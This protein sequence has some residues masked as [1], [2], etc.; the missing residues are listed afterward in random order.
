MRYLELLLDKLFSKEKLRC[1][2]VLM[3]PKVEKNKDKK[4]SMAEL[5]N[6]FG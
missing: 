1:D 6:Y 4:M 5:A 2:L 3:R